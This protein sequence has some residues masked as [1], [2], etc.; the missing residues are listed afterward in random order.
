[1]KIRTCYIE[2]FGALHRLK[3]SLN[4]GLNSLNE[5]NG[6]GK[7]TFAAFIAAMLYGFPDSDRDFIQSM[8]DTPAVSKAAGSV[9]GAASGSSSLSGSPSG[10][11]RLSYMP[12]QGGR[13]GGYLIFENNSR[14]YRVERYFGTTT[15][16]D[17]FSLT[18]ETT[19]E[20]CFDFHE[21]LGEELFGIDRDGYSNSAY[22]PQNNAS[23]EDNFSIQNKLRRLLKETSGDRRS[24]KGLKVLGALRDELQPPSGEEGKIS[25]LDRQIRQ[26][27]EEF[28]ENS[29]KAGDLKSLKDQEAKLTDSVSQLRGQ[30]EAAAE[31][32]SQLKSAN[33]SD[34]K[35]TNP[36]TA[37]TILIVMGFLTCWGAGAPLILYFSWMRAGIAAIAAGIVLMLSGTVLILRGR[38]IRKDLEIRC[39][40]AE[41]D[42]AALNEKL[43]EMENKRQA[44]LVRL[45]ET[46]ESL[47]TSELLHKRMESLHNE[48]QD[49]VRELD[50]LEKTISM[51]ELARSNVAGG[52]TDRL[53]VRFNELLHEYFETDMK[54]MLDED[55]EISINQGGR[56]HSLEMESF[57]LRDAANLCARFALVEILFHQNHPCIVLDD[58]LNNMDNERFARAMHMIEEYADRFQVI[59]LTCNESRMPRRKE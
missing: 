42:A 13:Y 37:G 22:I 9:S 8:R 58:V 51:L 25:L 41:N 24:A 19:H 16:M 57:G 2:N 38:R 52:Y 50:I 33:I 44:V 21:N 1:M 31:R 20:L 6:W 10:D 12:W 28:L 29:R 3:C 34:R 40:D 26:L 43:E 48:R 5:K 59:Y 18:L 47:K 36:V 45:E 23:L 53:R 4:D 14:L 11:P 46:G 27:E 30:A 35:L 56:I 54:V 7:S 17:T 32:L 39:G 49:A 55:F 15:A